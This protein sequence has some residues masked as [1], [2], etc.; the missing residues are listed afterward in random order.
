[1]SAPITADDLGALQRGM[2]AILGRVQSRV[3]VCAD[4]ST[5]TVLPEDLGDRVARFFRAANT[6]V[7]RAALVV[8]GGAT[9]FLQI[10][11]LL[12]EGS[13]P[14]APPSRPADSAPGSAPA[15]RPSRSDP[16][17]AKRLGSDPLMARRSE[18][19]AFR[20]AAEAAA[21]LDEVLNAE[22]SKRLRLFLEPPAS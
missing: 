13:S 4:L 6:R 2:A 17:L 21:W 19:R 7:E 8:G 3:V 16:L 20:T 22:E 18:R 12:R 15:S 1:M 14:L 10:E 11:R 9:F 5:A